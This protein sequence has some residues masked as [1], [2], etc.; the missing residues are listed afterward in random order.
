MSDKLFEVNGNRDKYPLNLNI[1]KYEKKV[2]DGMER[3]IPKYAASAQI[4]NPEYADMNGS[5]LSENERYIL[6]N[7]Q[8]CHFVIAD[9][10][11]LIKNS[12]RN[13]GGLT[14]HNCSQPYGDKKVY[15]VEKDGVFAHGETIKQAIANLNFKILQSKSAAEHVERIKKQGYVTL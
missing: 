12:T 4:G 10:I 1:L 8:F 5:V 11:L 14:I 15:L 3:W 9:G 7:K 2:I 13:K 6:Y